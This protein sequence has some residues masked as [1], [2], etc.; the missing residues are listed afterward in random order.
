MLAVA[1]QSLG[2]LTH[3]NKEIRVSRISLMDAMSRALVICA[4]FSTIA[5]AQSDFGSIGGF[6][7]DPSGAVV[8]KAK[9]VVTNEAT[10]EE[11]RVNTNDS[12]YY[13]VPNLAPG[14]YGMTAEAAGFKKFE[15]IHNTLNGNSALSLDAA[16]T[17]GSPTETVE[18]VGTAEVLQTD[19]GAVQGEITG[20]QIQSQELNGRNPLYMAQL[21]PGVRGGGTMGD[22]N[23]A[24]GGGEPFQINGA[25]TQDTIVTF[26]GAPSLRTRANG[27]VIGVADVDAVQEVQVMTADYSAEYGRAA[28]GQIRIISKSGTRDFHGSLYEYFRNSDLN[29]NTWTRNLSSLT[30]NATPFRYNNDSGTI[31]GP[32]WIPKMSSRWRDK[33]FFF[34]AE[35]W[36]RYRLVD[37]QTQA[38]PTA[39]MR[40]GN[41][42]ELLAPNPWYKA[43]TVVFDPS[44]CPS[45][46]AASC[47]PFPNNVIPTSQLSHNGVGILS[48]YPAAT[49]GFLSGT[50]NW[51]AT[52]PH[53]IDQRKGTMNIDLQPS[54]KHHIAGRRTDAS[55]LEFQPFD[56]GSGLTGKFFNRPNQTNTVSWT[57]TIS[58]SLISEARMTLS[59]DYVYIPVDPTLAGFHRDQFGIDYPY[60]LPNGKDQPQKIPTVNLPNFYGLAGGPYPSHSSGPIWTGGDT[61]TKVWRNHTIKAGISFEY[62][63]EN[64]GDQIN[65]ATVPGGASN[66]NG[67]FTFTDGRTGLGA[68]SGVGIANLALGLADSYTEIGPRALT[69]WRSAVVEEFVQDSWKVTS[70]LHLDYGIRVTTIHGF[71]PLWGNADYFNGALYNPAQAVQVDSKTGNVILGTG[72]PYNGVVIPGYSSFP[73]AAVGRVLAATPATAN[74]CDGASCTGLFAPNLSRSYINTYTPW[75]PRLGMA[76]QI[77]PKTVVRAG[78]GRFVTRMGLLD[79]VFMGGNSP[80]QPF[81]TVNNV[82]VDNPGASLTNGTAAPLTITTLNQKLK[83]PEAWNWNVTVQRELPLN[84]VLSV[85]YVSHRGLHAWQVYDINEPTVGALQANPGVNV[86]ALRPYKGYAAIQ[87]EESGVNSTYNALQISWSRA[88]KGGSSFG[89]TYT[90]SKSMDGGSNY[91]DIVPDTYNTSNLWGPSEYDTRHVAIVNYIYDLPFFKGKS[92]MTGKLLGGWEIAGTAQFQTGAPCGIGTNNDFAG[93]GEFGSF[94]C[95]SQG[96]FWVLNGTPTIS[97]GAFAGPVTTATSPKYFTANVTQPAAGTFNLQPGVRDAIYQPG[98]QDW[99]LALLKAFKVN[100]RSSFQFRAEAYDFINHPNLSAPQLTPTSGQFGMITSKTGLTRNLQLS[101]RFSF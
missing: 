80:F 33:L 97:T 11:H 42:S 37:T 44:T 101:L 41:F 47:T 72:N 48:A 58:P 14:V 85:G 100:E 94:G 93:V 62:S 52:A 3:K 23:F 25:R 73:S 51:L 76:Y 34:V 74:Q 5:T 43:G 18:V 68:T 57:W 64:D 53:P 96:Q 56:Q 26:D 24:V 13:T 86:N 59:L 31:G 6:A 19:S 7:K 77:S 39:L 15:S 27:A 83:P 29:A 1:K 35:D 95:G 61:V 28:G 70:K 98:L 90:Y 71:H 92:D 91:R 9:V 45:V 38:V 55:Y 66:Q 75:Q 87:E 46:G 63:G 4:L 89:F 49:A 36:I 60:L 69:I 30:T 54:E 78:I 16:F 32:A 10:G 88:F 67:T 17:V 22:F 84:T 8:P 2:Q 81:V 21:L 50:Q 65:V 79:N 99:N 20:T 12:G 82:S 40:S